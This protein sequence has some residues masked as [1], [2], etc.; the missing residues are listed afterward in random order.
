MSRA[1]TRLS[2]VHEKVESLHMEQVYHISV[3]WLSCDC[4]V[5]FRVTKICM[6]LAR[7]SETMLLSWDLLG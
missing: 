4:H 6:Y 7:L 2:E 5:T 3:L 1:L